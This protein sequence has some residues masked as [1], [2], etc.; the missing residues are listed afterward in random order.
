LDITTQEPGAN[1]PPL[2]ALRGISKRYGGV[3]ALEDVDFTAHAGSIHAILGENG[4]GKS[5]LI[6]IIAG[7]VQPDTGTLAINGTPRILPDP[8]AA[9]AAGVVCVF[10]ELSLLPDLSVADN[11]AITTPPRRFGLIDRRAQR[12]HA[13]KLL[14]RV[15]CE[16]INPVMLVRD[17]PLSRRQMVEIAKALG[18]APRLL[19]L[20]EATSAL[21]SA[22]VEKAYAILLGLRDEGLG[23]LYISHRM[24]E[25]EKLADACSVFRNGRHIETFAQ[26]SRSPADIVQMMIGRD[27]RSTY[28]PKPAYR[29]AY[30]ADNT[31]ALDAKDLAWADRL[32]GIDL[33]VGRGEIVGLG[34][35]DGQG[36]RDLLLALFGALRGV[37]G[38]VAID[39]AARAIASPAMAKHKRIGMA[40]IPEDRKTEGLMLPMSVAENTTLAALPGFTRGIVVDRGREAAGIAAMID[41]LRIK[42]A[43]PALPVATFSGG[44]QQKVVIAKWLLTAPRIVLLCDPTRGIDVGTKQEIYQLLRDLADAGT[45][46]VLYSTDYDELVGCCD[47]VLI[48]Y[49]GRIV[50][51]LAGDAI[52]GPAIVA[53][54]LNI[55][56]AS[57]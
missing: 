17:L 24:H 16:D 6:K 28:P 57:A 45:A 35:L 10:Q 23:L 47:R 3:R 41:K 56:A 54:S 22:D 19:I 31:P 7:V 21:T 44:N 29:P 52:T 50:R 20:D 38:T 43:D 33:R 26:G 46:I 2:L 8:Q 40:L 25:I 30:W 55:T 42:A 53:A 11:I 14:A 18:R 36:Q 48:L 9:N 39:G 32:H 1:R 51:E 4:A 13:E 12:R 37:S 27:I 49:D 5:T 15:G 34:G